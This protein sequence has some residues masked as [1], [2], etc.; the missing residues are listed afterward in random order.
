MWCEFYFLLSW[1]CSDIYTQLYSEKKSLIP[2]EWDFRYQ[3]TCRGGGEE[4]LHPDPKSQKENSQTHEI[5]TGP[6]ALTLIFPCSSR[7]GLRPLLLCKNRG[8]SQPRDQTQVSCVAGGFFTSWAT[9]ETK[10][11]GVGSL[12]LLQWI[13]LTQELNWGLLHCR[14]IRNQLSYQGSL[15]REPRGVFNFLSFML[16]LYP[17][18]DLFPFLGTKIS[19]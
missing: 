15:L 7:V 5:Q 6:A 10:N 19:K 18:R 12:S 1:D 16:N 9:R 14:Q 17:Q 8:S 11:A 4:N 2:W 3:K 13:F